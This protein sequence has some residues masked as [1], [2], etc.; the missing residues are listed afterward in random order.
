[1]SQVIGM[2][3][4]SSRAPPNAPTIVPQTLSAAS[5]QGCTSMCR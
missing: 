1:M 3:T 2:P 5:A 4:L